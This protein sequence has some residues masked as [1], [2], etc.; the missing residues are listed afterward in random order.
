MFDRRLV[1]SFDWSLLL[2]SLLISSLGIVNLYSTGPVSSNPVITP[3]YMKQFYWLLVGLVFFFTIVVIDYQLFARHAYL[4]HFVALLLLLIALLWGKPSAGTHRWLQIGGISFQP[5]EFAKIT[6]VLLFSRSFS[7][8]SMSA[9][10]QF[11]G[12]PLPSLFTF[13]T[14]LLVFLGPD[15]GVCLPFSFSLFLFRFFNQVRSQ[16]N[17]VA[18]FLWRR[19]SSRCL[20]VFRRLPKR[21]YCFLFQPRKRF[22]SGR[23]PGTTIKNR[24]RLR[25]VV[26]KGVR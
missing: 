13:S 6:L 5:S 16:A 1:S 14:F 10:N 9:H 21:T 20:A 17:F 22:P 12:V 18:C 8:A 7:K 19:S 11:Q 24:H 4:F 26:W 2:S 25:Y 3:L 15:L 23:L